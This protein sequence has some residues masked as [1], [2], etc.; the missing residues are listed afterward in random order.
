MKGSVWGTVRWV[1]II[2]V[3]VL[4]IV[5]LF[6]R[7]FQIATFDPV[8]AAS[9]GINVVAM[10]YLLTA[11]TS[12]VVVGAVQVV[13]VVLVVGLLVTPAA[14]AYLLSDRLTRMLWLAALFGVTSVLSGL[15]L[16]T[17]IDVASGPAIVI[18][19]T[20]QFMFVLAC[21]VDRLIFIVCKK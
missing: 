14:T 10:N 12:L 19:R 17:L 15:Y 2:A 6:F 8:M 9:I 1:A 13:G 21:V 4:T 20:A 5:I 3:V 11:C 7:Q 18:M 16:S